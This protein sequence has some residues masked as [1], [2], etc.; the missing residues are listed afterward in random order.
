MSLTKSDFITT[1]IEQ[2]GLSKKDY[3]G[4]NKYCTTSEVMALRRSYDLQYT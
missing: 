1:L 2:A 4:N 3:L